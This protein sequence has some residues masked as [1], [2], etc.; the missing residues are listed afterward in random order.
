MR[1]RLF[2]KRASRA[3]LLSR[4]QHNF[5]RLAFRD[6]V[7][8]LDLRTRGIVEY[9]QKIHQNDLIRNVAA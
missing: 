1:S 2:L 9:L 8:R 4:S 3:A 7:D 6:W 5:N